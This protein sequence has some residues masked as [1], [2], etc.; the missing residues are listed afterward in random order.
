M[1]CWLRVW[2]RGFQVHRV[3]T[4]IFHPTP[5]IPRH[6]GSQWRVGARSIAFSAGALQ[7][8]SC[9]PTLPS[10]VPIGS[11]AGSL[12]IPWKS[13]LK[14]PFPPL[15][16]EVVGDVGTCLPPPE[17]RQCH[18]FDFSRVP[19]QGKEGLHFWT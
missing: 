17:L 9:S 19:C 14:S 13:T 11:S 12:G 6:Q 4:F 10:P 2:G 18:P 8:S 1:A 5:R 3:E 15:N 16:L 7:D